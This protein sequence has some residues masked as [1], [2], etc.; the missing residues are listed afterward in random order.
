[1]RFNRTFSQ[2]RTVYTLVIAVATSFLRGYGE[3]QEERTTQKERF[4]QAEAGPRKNWAPPQKVCS[5]HVDSF[6]VDN[7]YRPN[8]DHFVVRA[9]G[10]VILLVVTVHVRIESD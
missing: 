3:K 10:G 4:A 1:M 2:K 5:M 6:L 9:C 7:R 8:P